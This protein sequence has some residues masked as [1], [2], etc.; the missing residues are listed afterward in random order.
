MGASPLAGRKVVLGVGGGI[1]A[2]KSVELLR[3]LTGAGAAVD[4]VLTE[5]ACRFVA[6]LTFAALSGRPAQTE[7]FGAVDPIPHTRLGQSADLVVVAPATADLIA[8]VAGGLA[9]DLL[10]NTILATRAPLVAAAAMHTEMWEHPATRRNVARLRTD[11]VTLVDPESGPLAGGDS[12]PGR[13]AEPATILAVC[14]RVLAP[15]SGTGPG[16]EGHS[17]LV[18]AGGTREPIDPVRYVGNRSSGKMGHAVAAAAAARGAAVTLVTT[19]GLPTPGGVDRIDVETAAELADAVLAR[20]PRTDAVV[21]TAAVAD[22]RPVDPAASKL[23]KED[24]PPR[25]VLEPTLDVLAEMGKRKEAQV[26][27]GFAAE[28]DDVARRGSA[29]VHAKNLDLLVANLVGVADS[30]FGAETDRAYFCHPG[31]H[32][33]ELGLLAKDELAGLICDRLAALLA[34]PGASRG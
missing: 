33:E 22:F 1:A 6:P 28:T 34:E 8:R 32:V 11:G 18:S 24:G 12:G 21:M 31:D 27:V 5:A 26:L 7:L 30:G 29:K 15:G 20:F 9:D 16:L 10:T 2:Y 13:M 19:S 4:C 14:E 23:K 25:I 3:L 17:V